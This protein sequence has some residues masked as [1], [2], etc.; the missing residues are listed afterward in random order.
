MQRLRKC[1]KG[2]GKGGGAQCDDDD[3]FVVLETRV[4]FLSASEWFFLQKSALT[5]PTKYLIKHHLF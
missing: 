5:F 4:H 3:D 1:F 2:G